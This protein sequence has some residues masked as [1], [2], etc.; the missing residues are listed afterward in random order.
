V[1]L[2]ASGRGTVLVTA[3]VHANVNHVSGTS[4]SVLFYLETAASACAL[5]V[6]YAVA[7]VASN[8][9]TGLYFMT[10]GV[11]EPFSIAAA[12]TYTYYVSARMAGGGDAGD[13]FNGGGAVAVFYPA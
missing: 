4:D 10:V 13:V 11:E 12:G 7:S 5:G 3:Q 9:P 1:S 8:Q 2:A 6:F